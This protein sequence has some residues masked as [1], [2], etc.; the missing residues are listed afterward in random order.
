MLSSSK[1]A[2]PVDGF[3]AS[4]NAIPIWSMISDLSEVGGV[5]MGWHSSG[6]SQPRVVSNLLESKTMLNWVH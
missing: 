1:V 3:D 2:K 5:D 6:G 4:H